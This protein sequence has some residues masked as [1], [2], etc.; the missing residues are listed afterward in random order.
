MRSS[1]ARLLVLSLLAPSCSTGDVAVGTSADVIADVLADGLSDTALPGTDAP[2]T[3]DLPPKAD[4]GPGPAP[5]ANALR[6]SYIS[7]DSYSGLGGANG[8]VIA[9]FYD[10]VPSGLSTTSEQIG[11]CVVNIT[12]FGDGKFKLE[13]HRV[14]TITLSGGLEPVTMKPGPGGD[15]P[16]FQGKAALWLGGEPLVFDATGG[17]IPGFSATVAAPSH[18]RIT[19]PVLPIGKALPLPRSSDLALA[20]TGD[21]AGQVIYRISGPQKLPAPQTTLTCAFTPSD[22]KGTVPKAALG[23]IALTGTGTISA[24]SL[25]AAEP[26]AGL[27]DAVSIQAEARALRPSDTPWLGTVEIQ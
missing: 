9:G 8:T 12:T 16:A 14:G 6:V 7:A 25:S 20:W 18:V 15:Y 11:P 24:T 3:N 13:K 21:S 5:K 4:V 22:G 23:K 1:L 27:W 17:D 2:A 19:A 10:E 26:K